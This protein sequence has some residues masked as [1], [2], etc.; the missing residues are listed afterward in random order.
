MSPIG[1]PDL[2]R[3]ALVRAAVV[4]PADRL[5]AAGHRALRRLERHGAHRV[6]LGQDPIL[7]QVDVRAVRPDVLDAT[8]DEVEATP[9][10]EVRV[11]E[12][13]LFDEL[14]LVRGP[15]HA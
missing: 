10:T 12:H 15:A 8:L 11:L 14:L 5:V 3:D 2:L 7:I 4:G 1:S 9:T 6:E 13:R